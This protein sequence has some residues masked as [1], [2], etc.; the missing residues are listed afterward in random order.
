MTVKMSRCVAVIAVIL[1]CSVT[2]LCQFHECHD[3]PSISP[4]DGPL[5]DMQFTWLG[6]LQYIHIK[7]GLP[8]YFRV[9]RVVLISR[10]FVLCTAMDA[11]QVPEDHA[12]GNIVFGDYERDEAEC[13]L[14]VL[15]LA[16]GMECPAAVMLMPIADV[17]LHPEYKHFGAKNSIALLKMLTPVKS[18]YMLPAC[19]PFRNFLLDREGRQ[20]REQIMLIDFTADAPRDFAE[21]EEKDLTR[22]NLL[23]KE[24][25]YLY[26]PKESERNATKITRNRMICTTGCGYHSGA[27]SIVHEHTGHWS[28]VS[29]AVGGPPCPDPLRGR[30]PPSPPQHIAIYP[31]VPWITAAITGKAV[32]AFDKDDPF[33]YLMPRQAGQESAAYETHFHEWVGHWWYGGA[34]CHDRGDN[35]LDLFKFYHEYFSLKPLAETFLTYYLQIESAMHT[36]VICV[37]VGMPYQYSQPNVTDIDTPVVKVRIPLLRFRSMY[38]FQVQAYAYNAT[39]TSSETSSTEEVA[40]SDYEY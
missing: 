27:P 19:L 1:S 24:L 30:H 5:A 13:G 23:P 39:E 21:S 7:T 40:S 14:S 37:K 4:D 38:M 28:L 17:L 15:D 8:H 20:T 26:D 12:L 33:G 2:I 3:D 11:A 36:T 18:G 31:Y 25:C 35:A 22:I 16:A 6:A 29:L 10:L 34:R 32:G 9:P